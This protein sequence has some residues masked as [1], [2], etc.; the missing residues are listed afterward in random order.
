MFEKDAFERN[1]CTIDSIK[2]RLLNIAYELEEEGF[3]RKAKSLETIVAKL[4]EWEN[5]K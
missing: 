4:E 3:R 5:K 2:E 1:L